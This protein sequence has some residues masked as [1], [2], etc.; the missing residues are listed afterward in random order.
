MGLNVSS[1][2]DK[3]G[4]QP[5][6]TTGAPEF[7]RAF[8][9]QQNTLEALPLFLVP[10]WLAALWFQPARWLPAVVALV[11]IA[12]RFIYM[13]DYVAADRARGPGLR[14]QAFAMVANLVLAVA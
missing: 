1:M 3:H 12:G 6:A 4:V 11:W 2:R 7:E 10:L 13:H 9:V 5:P 14:I 8:R